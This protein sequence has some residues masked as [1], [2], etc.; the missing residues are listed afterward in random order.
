MDAGKQRELKGQGDGNRK[1]IV[2][3]NKEAL[4]V[5]EAE[6]KERRRQRDRDD[7]GRERGRERG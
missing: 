3:R 5:E 2:E 1:E 6:N 7:G 4:G